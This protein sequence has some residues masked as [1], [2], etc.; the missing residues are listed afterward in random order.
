MDVAKSSR[1]S[2]DE[3]K[4]AAA[5]CKLFNS[6]TASFGDVSMTATARSR[7]AARLSG[8]ALVS[9]LL[10]DFVDGGVLMGGTM[11]V[12]LKNSLVQIFLT[13]SLSSTSALLSRFPD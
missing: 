12:F 6:C 1:H 4:V 10:L 5:G 7:R 13:L 2:F 11:S 9:S 8:E 3:N